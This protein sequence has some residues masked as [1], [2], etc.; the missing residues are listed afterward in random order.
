MP[1][2]PVEYTQDKLA[3]PAEI[4][5][6]SFKFDG[7]G[8]LIMPFAPYQKLILTT[9]P[10]SKTVSF[11]TESPDSKPAT[12]PGS[13]MTG[14]LHAETVITIGPT[15]GW[16]VQLSGGESQYP[17]AY[18]DGDNVNFYVDNEGNV[19]VAG[20]ITAIS[21]SIGGWTIENYY[22][23]AGSG[24]NI[25]GMSPADYP[26]WAGASFANR[27]TAPFRVTQAGLIVCANLLVTGIEEGSEVSIQNWQLTCEFS[28]TDY[29]TVAWG[30]GV[31]TT[32]DGSEYNISSG[33]SGNVGVYNYI[34]WDK[35]SSTILQVTTDSAIALGAGKVLVGV[36][37]PNG[38]ATKDI[39]FQIFSGKGG[40]SPS[41]GVGNIVAGV[42]TTTELNF[43][44][45]I[46]AGGTGEIIA[47][48]NASGEAGALKI[49]AARIEITGSTT[50]ASGYDPTDKVAIVDA[51]DMAYEDL[52][53]LS[54]LGTTVVDGG[55]LKTILIDAQ[56][57]QTGILTGRTV[58]SSAGVD[59]VQL[60]NTDDIEFYKGGAV[61]G[62]IFTGSSYM[63][64]YS[65]GAGVPIILGNSVDGIGL[66]V[67]GDSVT[68]KIL[69]PD[70][71]NSRN[72]GATNYRWNQLLLNNLIDFG[73]AA[74][75]IQVG[76][77]VALA[78]TSTYIACNEHFLPNVNDEF[79]L[80]SGS[81]KWQ[82]LFLSGAATV[83]GLISGGLLNINISSANNYINA[84]LYLGGDLVFD[85]ANRN[86]KRGAD[87][88]F[89]LAAAQVNVGKHLIPSA[90]DLTLGNAGNKWFEIW[91]TSQT[92][93]K[94]I[95]GDLNFKFKDKVV[96]QIKEDE[97]GLMFLNKNK[98]LV[99]R[100]DQ[101]GNLWT[102]G[103]TKKL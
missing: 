18:T 83:D 94:H 50:F 33:N 1:K 91:C 17:I 64:I 22:L 79:D 101:D 49:S 47:T 15:T 71:T 32:A 63:T 76:G 61:I 38:D 82:D 52:V 21:G 78:F 99:M 67:L 27:S 28:S 45:I 75:N 36:C 42:I 85:A 34:Y 24:A 98:Q 37:K 9:S 6:P 89:E 58:R 7:R 87:V 97:K 31:L 30:A 84:A 54:K 43:T 41:V 96:F 59:R 57:I 23:Y 86:I 40:M 46:S 93:D 73:A 16:R 3:D 103:K 66:F 80:G 51:G 5:N 48:I 55:Y 11:G 53:E 56:F 92:A 39:I 14:Y 35:D 68:S 26:F 72:L 95:T 20:S 29:N 8:R 65:I 74:A 100:L 19:F 77:A 25:C 70:T 44:P 62:K 13:I 4:Y 81:W 2:F 10:G 102:K 12:D 60:A 88:C 69:L 90:G